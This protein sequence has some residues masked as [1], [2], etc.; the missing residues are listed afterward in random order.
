VPEKRIIEQI[1][2]HEDLYDLCTGLERVNIFIHA[3]FAYSAHFL[4]AFYGE[5]IDDGKIFKY[6]P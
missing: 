1:G 2:L 5:D 4:G 6:Y 3:F